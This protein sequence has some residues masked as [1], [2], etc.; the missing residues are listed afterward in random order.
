VPVVLETQNLQKSG[1]Y[2]FCYLDGQIEGVTIDS[3]EEDDQKT[4]EVVS[5]LVNVK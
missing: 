2:V 1:V 3:R 4:E 5:R